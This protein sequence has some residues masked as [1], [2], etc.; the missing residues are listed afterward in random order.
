M[1]TVLVTGGTGMLGSRLVPVL[2]AR[3]HEVRVLSRHLTERRLP[4]GA[5]AAVGNVRTAAGLDEAVADVDAIIHA[6]TSPQRRAKAT[7]VKGTAHMLEAAANAGVSNFIYVSI[8]GVDRHRFPYYRAK[9]EAEQLVEAATVGWTIQRA[10]QFH[11]LLDKFLSLRAF[12]ATRNM[13]FQPIDVDEVSRSLADRIDEGPSGRVA[14]LGG[15]EVLT[16]R[17]LRNIRREITGRGSA[18]VPAPAVGFLR[19]FDDGHQLAPE[20]RFGTVTWPD[21]LSRPT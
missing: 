5:T 10:T 7:E 14:D 1:A 19:D 13:A 8:A 11:G 6:A 3:G 16:L 4:A 15:P 17:E 20:H 12:P 21:W 18:L 2:L 9:W